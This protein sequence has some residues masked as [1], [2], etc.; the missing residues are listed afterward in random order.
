[1]DIFEILKK[2]IG[3]LP[4]L[5]STGVVGIEAYD[6]V[7]TII[8]ERRKPNEPEWDELE[9]MILKNQAIVRDT[10]RDV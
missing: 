10:S 6:R 7:S 9:S 8:R 4:D 5:I 1:M 3:L 2:Y